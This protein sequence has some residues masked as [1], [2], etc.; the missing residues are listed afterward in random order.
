MILE[1]VGS[2]ETSML[3]VGSKPVPIASE[4]VKSG[5]RNGRHTVEI[6]NTS[7]SLVYFGGKDVTTVAGIP[8]KAGER[9]VF[10]V[11]SIAIDGIFAISGATAM[12]VIAEY[13]A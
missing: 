3:T 11:N 12:V 4:K 10:P 5:K 8:I 6:Y 9:R 1:N 13:F 2:I 7:E